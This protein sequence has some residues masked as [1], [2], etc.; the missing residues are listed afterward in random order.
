M[1]DFMKR[2]TKTALALCLAVLGTGRLSIRPWRHQ[3]ES[4]FCTKRS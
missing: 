4:D 1:K 3:G 2:N